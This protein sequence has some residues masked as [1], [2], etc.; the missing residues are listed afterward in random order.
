MDNL[1]GDIMARTIMQANY[2]YS[3]EEA[4][5]R[6]RYILAVDGYCEAEE[7]GEIVWIGGGMKLTGMPAIKVDFGGNTV[8]LSGWIKGLLGSETPLHGMLGASAKRDVKET[9]AKLQSALSANR[10]K[11]N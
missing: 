1:K 9:M 7:D 8:R 10:N 4:E 11:A 6:A 2:E 5:G 3:K